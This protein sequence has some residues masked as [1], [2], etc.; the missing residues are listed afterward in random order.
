C[1]SSVQMKNKQ[2][3][4]SATP[5]LDAIAV[6]MCLLGVGLFSIT[7]LAYFVPEVV[8]MPGKKVSTPCSTFQAM[9]GLRTH[10]IAT[11]AAPVI[12][13]A[14]RLIQ[15]DA[16]GY[17]QWST[18]QGNYWITGTTDE[19]LWILLGQQQ[20][21]IYDGDNAT[22]KPGDIVLDCGAHVGVFTR[23]A[24][25]RGAKL[26]VA[27]EPAPENVECLQRNF[28]QE[29]AQGRVIVYPKGV[30]NK[31]DVLPMH[32]NRNS[33][34]DSFVL[35]L[36]PGQKVMNLPLT[37]IDQ[38]VS[39]VRLAHI[40]FIKMDIKGAEVPAL[41]GAARTLSSNQPR[42]SVASEHL[43]N[44]PI[45]IPQTVLTTNSRYH[46]AC[47]SCYVQKGEVRPEVLHFYRN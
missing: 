38:I 3:S 33:A 6:I 41:Q 19:A 28:S 37:T 17:H 21:D 42:I 7:A 8:T 5:V 31:N 4:K 13:Q 26:V 24:L 20:V 10:R 45:M 43:D 32:L 47:G 9:R 12:K 36:D 16:A 27:I 40:D 11:Q 18:P 29:I 39:D 34:G 2:P 15:R 35:D 25:K 14:S 30:W 23:T 46:V 22:V 44:D 1:R